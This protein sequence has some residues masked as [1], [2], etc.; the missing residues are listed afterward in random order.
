MSTLT[1]PAGA[2]RRP[3]PTTGG[4]P[5]PATGRRPLLIVLVVLAVL[6][7]V[8]AS[9]LRG[10]Y[11]DGPL[12][13]DAPTAQGSKAVVEVLGELGVEVGVQRHTADAAESLR[14]GRTV[15]VTDPAALSGAQLDA[16]AAAHEESAGRLVL[17]QPDF[18]TLSYFSP[19]LVPE[20]VLRAPAVV[21]AGSGC[22]DLSH[23]A[24]VLSVPGAEGLRG[25]ATLYRV[26]GDAESCFDVEGGS[27]V[28]RDGELLVL[29]SA[30]LLTNETVGEADNSALALNALGGAGQLTWYVPSATD[31]MGTASQSLTSHLPDWAGP[32][33]LWLLM[34]SAIALVALGRRF[35]PVVIE[36]LP[37]TVRPQEMVRGRARLLQQSGERDAAATALRTAA[38]RRLADTLGLRHER[39]LDGLIAALR[40]HVDHSPEQLRALLGPAPVTSDQDLV[41][42]AHDLDR[43]EKEIDR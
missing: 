8:L 32:L 23:R 9:V 24:R 43:L 38:A 14:A 21:P 11:Q 25:P 37:V 2:T 41:R 7:A 19:L 28:A 18:I 29:G 42:L 31:P 4:S 26:A 5:A 33:G 10:L 3:A 30:D 6:A 1:A 15:L 17:V 27:L 12:E 20:G 39:A 34:V 13:P 35:G 22:G 16:L 40:A 36:P